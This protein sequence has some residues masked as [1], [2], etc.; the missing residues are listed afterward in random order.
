M[1]QTIPLHSFNPTDEERHKMLKF[2]LKLDNRLNDFDEIIK[3]MSPPEDIETI[4]SKLQ[5]KGVKVAVIGAGSA[6][7]CVSY[8]LNKIGCDITIFE[9]SKRIGGRIKTHYFDKDSNQL[10][11]LGAMR[12]GIAHETVWNY[13]KKFKLKTRPFI[14]KSYS[15]LFYIR[16]S[17][18]LNEPSAKSIMENIYPKFKLSKLEK[19]LTP[20]KLMSQMYN[21]Y[22]YSLTSNEKTELIK[23]KQSYSHKIKEIQNLSLRQAYENTNLSQDAISMI[24]Y[25]SSLEADLLHISLYEILGELY[26]V[27]FAYNYTIEGGMINLPLS[28]YNE[29]SSSDGPGKVQFKFGHLVNSII[30][31]PYRDKI[32]LEVTDLNDKNVY[33]REFDYVVCCIPFSSLRRVK[34]LPNFSTLKM[35]AI[36]ELNYEIGQKTFLYL[37]ERFWE[38]DNPISGTTLTDLITI[39]TLYGSDHMEAIPNRLFEYRLIENTSYKTPGVLLASYNWHQNAIRLGSQPEL[40]KIKEVSNCIESIHKLPEN[41]IEDNIIDYST[42]LWSNIP[43]IW[44][45]VSLLTPGQKELFLY[46]ATLPEMNDRVFFA[47][48]HVSTKHGWQQGSYQSAMLCAN[49]IAKSIRQ[50]D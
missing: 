5:G 34:I 8:E 18:A 16:D 30:K 19:K 48:E 41:Y 33:Y 11:E 47:G 44:G 17:H 36:N 4:C 22:F 31:S 20:S 43:F 27:D 9:A 39:S 10:A 25:L 24:S 28:F 13:I 49:N 3:L 32:I 37:K 21:K 38:K 12:I 2:L 26:T 6:G 45:G 14:S 46:E 29:L 50:R 23:I 35:Q 40:I 42:I 15:S 7:L 1:Q